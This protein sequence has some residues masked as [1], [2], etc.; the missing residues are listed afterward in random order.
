MVKTGPLDM[1]IL[2]AFAQVW[3]QKSHFLDLLKLVFDLFRD[4][5]RYCFQPLEARFLSYFELKTLIR[6]LENIKYQ[7]SVSKRYFRDFFKITWK[8]FGV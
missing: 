7:F 6:D 1:V 3:A 4:G 2:A 5:F 8:L